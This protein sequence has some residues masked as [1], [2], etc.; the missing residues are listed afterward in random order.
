MDLDLNAEPVRGVLRHEHGPDK[1]FDGWVS[2]I[3]A[4]ELALDDECR[5][6]DQRIEEERFLS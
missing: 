5:H 1:P 2:L 3:R 4:L 6:N